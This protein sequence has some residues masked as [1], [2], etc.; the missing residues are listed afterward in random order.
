M[1]EQDSSLEK[2]DAEGQRQFSLQSVREA[3]E[4]L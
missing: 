2:Q 3:L 1:S 4:N